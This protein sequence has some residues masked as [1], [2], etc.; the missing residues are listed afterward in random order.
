M[1]ENEINAVEMVRAIRDRMNE[2]TKGMTRE[3]FLEYIHRKAERV[4][5][6]AT[7]ETTK[8][9]RPAA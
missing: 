9:A 6:E 4:L 1:D 8:A 2:E 3:Q 5:A 7:A